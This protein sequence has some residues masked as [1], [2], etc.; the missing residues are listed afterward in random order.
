MRDV[1]A[2]PIAVVAGSNHHQSRAKGPVSQHVMS[3]TR[4]ILL[5][6]VLTAGA[7]AAVRP[8]FLQEPEMPEVTKHHERLAAGV[9]DWE[10]TLTMFMPGMDPQPM[11]AAESVVAVGPYWTTSKFTADMGAMA[12]VGA[13]SLGYDSE[14]KQYVGTWID[15]T[16]TYL[17][18]MHGEFDDAKGALVMHW[19]GPNWV[20]GSGTTDYRSETVQRAD[21]YVST[22]Y[23]GEGAGTKHMEIKMK[24]KAVKGEK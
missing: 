11:P 13:S 17:T 24:R 1:A 9:G 15:S 8:T 3:R 21:A 14:K 7:F 6:L 18:V 2:L 16:T 23:M 4:T 10:G 19:Q 12:F 5:S 22:F 20:A